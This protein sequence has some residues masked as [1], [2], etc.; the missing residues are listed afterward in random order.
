MRN[1]AIKLMFLL[2]ILILNNNYRLKQTIN[3]PFHLRTIQKSLT[4][5]NNIIL[6]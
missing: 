6:K 2:F 3:H 4:K 5:I 1:I